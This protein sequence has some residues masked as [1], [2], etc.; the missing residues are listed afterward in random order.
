MKYLCGEENLLDLNLFLNLKL[1]SFIL[2]LYAYTLL[3][4]SFRSVKKKEDEFILLFCKN[5]LHW[6]IVTVKI[7]IMIPRISI[8]N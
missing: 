2:Y 4:N 5:A 1:K 6:S 7:F 3:F 8:L